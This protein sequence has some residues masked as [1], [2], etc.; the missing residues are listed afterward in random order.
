MSSSYGI[1]STDMDKYVTVEK[2]IPQ[3]DV[4]LYERMDNSRNT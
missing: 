3:S 4:W 2:D 1:I